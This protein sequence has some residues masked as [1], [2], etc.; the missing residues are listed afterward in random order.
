M[1]RPE[2]TPLNM[3]SVFAAGI[4]WVYMLELWIVVNV[5]IYMAIFNRP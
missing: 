2:I 1:E 3:L 4:V 5:L